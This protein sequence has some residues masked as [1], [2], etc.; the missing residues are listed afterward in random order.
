MQDF[1]NFY[2]TW[3][4]VSNKKKLLHVAEFLKVLLG[5]V[6]IDPLFQN[7][8]KLFYFGQLQRHSRRQKLEKLKDFAQTDL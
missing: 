6:P 4:D 8:K 7:L 1:S 2:Q 3:R 5:K